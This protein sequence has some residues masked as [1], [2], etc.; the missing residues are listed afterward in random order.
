ML[1]LCL[2]RDNSLSHG[3]VFLLL[4]NVS[5]GVLKTGLLQPHT[6]EVQ[7]Q[8]SLSANVVDVSSVSSA[9]CHQ[10]GLDTPR[11]ETSKKVILTIFCHYLITITPQYCHFPPSYHQVWI[12]FLKYNKICKVSTMYRNC[13]KRFFGGRGT[14][15]YLSPSMSLYILPSTLELYYRISNIQTRSSHFWEH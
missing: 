7:L 8:S 11:S 10:S 4:F 9:S 5:C 2:D 1:P 13:G 12:K 3:F 6:F 14:R 15:V